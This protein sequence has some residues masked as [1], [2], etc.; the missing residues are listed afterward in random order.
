MA[1][2]KHGSMDVTEQQKTFDGFMSFTVKTTAVII[3]LVIMLAVF[4]A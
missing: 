3:F 4:N 2:H 1:E